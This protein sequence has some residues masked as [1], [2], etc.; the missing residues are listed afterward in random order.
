MV[1]LALAVLLAAPPR[2]PAAP[3]GPDVAAAWALVRRLEGVW[4]SEGREGRA[5]V[6][7]RVVAGGAAVLETVTGADRAV[8]TGMST[9]SVEHGELVV[10]HFGAQ[11]T[12]RLR[13]KALEGGVLRLEAT[14]PSPRVAAL[15]L[16]VKDA[17]LVQEWVLRDV[18]GES[19]RTLDL[20]REYVDTLK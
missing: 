16:T 14:S 20:R 10:T 11:G 3:P 7:V 4:R 6:T 5:F 18:A 15:T 8:V 1:T 2:A 19:R 13:A 12:T 17:A 9:W